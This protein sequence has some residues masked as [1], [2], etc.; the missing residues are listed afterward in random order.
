MYWKKVL[1]RE[2]VSVLNKHRDTETRRCFKRKI[3]HR[4]LHFLYALRVS[5]LNKN[6]ETRRCLITHIDQF[7]KLHSST[8]N[9]NIYFT[10]SQAKLHYLV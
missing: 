5:V 9:S 7:S 2:C 1:F 3:T 6:T 8:N 10:A 4:S